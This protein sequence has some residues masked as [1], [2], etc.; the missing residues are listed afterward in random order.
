M[1]LGMRYLDVGNY[2]RAEAIFRQEQ[3]KQQEHRLASS[4]QTAA[5]IYGMVIAESQQGRLREAQSH[6]EELLQITEERIYRG[7]FGLT[8]ANLLAYFAYFRDHDEALTYS[9]LRTNLQ[10]PGWRRLAPTTALLR[11]SRVLD[12]LAN[13]SPWLSLSGPGD[14]LGGRLSGPTGRERCPAADAAPAAR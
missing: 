6:L 12:E 5:T 2:E 9:L 11:K 3:A 10:D 1:T 13:A 4:A 14:R 7:R 8:E